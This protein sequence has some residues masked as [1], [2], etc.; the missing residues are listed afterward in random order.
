M[1]DGLLLAL[2]ALGRQLLLGLGPLALLG[3]VL[4]WLQRL[5]QLCLA[6]A[7]GPKG[8]IYWTGWIG[9][10]IHEFSH[11][12][13]GYAFGIKILEVQLFKPDPETGVLGYVRWEEPPLHWSRLHSIVGTFLMG[14]APLFGGGLVL[15]L[16][17]RF[18]CPDPGAAW[19]AAESFSEVAQRGGAHQALDGL[20]GLVRGVYSAVFAHGWGSWRAWVFLYLALAV[21]SHLAPSSAD[22]RGGG[23][24]LVVLLVLLVLGNLVAVILGYDPRS[25]AGGLARALGP[26]TALLVLTATVCLGN[27]AICGLLFAFTAGSRRQAG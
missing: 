12:M 4:Y 22:L 21:G 1:L 23:R 8:V 25:W 7:I 18:L 27:L 17:L 10:P 2:N 9:T 6:R 19:A 14:V 13:V 5:T 11:A 3:V 26:V 15:L 16:L 24:G 20:G